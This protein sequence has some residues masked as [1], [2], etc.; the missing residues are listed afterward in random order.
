MVKPLQ[1]DEIEFEK[2]SVD[3]KRI[4]RVRRKGRLFH[5][6]GEEIAMFP[7]SVMA[8]AID[9]NVKT[10]R[11]WELDK[12]WPLPQWKVPDK[13]CKRWYSSNQVIA[14][15]A[16]Y[17]RLSRGGDFGLSHSPYFP[18]D[19]FLKFV[20]DMFY[21]VDAEVVAQARKNQ[22]AAS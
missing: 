9:R 10:I 2:W 19:E 3:A 12:L 18:L 17:K 20:K 7:I 6:G 11:R 4:V 13:R 21:K 16:E 14:I 22:K 5:V 8:D 15:N 1:K